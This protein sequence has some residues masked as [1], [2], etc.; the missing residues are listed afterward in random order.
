MKSVKAGT[1]CIFLLI[2]AG[3]LSHAATETEELDSLEV[4]GYLLGL[5]EPAPPEIMGDVVV[6]T[7]SSSLR[8]VGI[9]FADEG[10][11]SVHWF[12]PLMVSEDPLERLRRGKNASPYREAGISFHVREIPR[13]LDRLEYRLVING[14]W[15][16]DPTNPN[17]RRDGISGS[18][19]SVLPLPPSQPYGPVSVMQGGG[20]NLVF[21]GPPGESV[22]VAGSFNNWDPFMYE[23]REGPAGVYTIRI[24]L[25][26]G[27]YQ[28]VFFHRGERVVDQFNHSRVFSR[29][30][31]AASEIVVQNDR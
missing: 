20:L 21:Q 3:G 14:L 29:E 26:A 6:F 16:V 13:G 17:T 27:R 7:A 12:R 2:F 23:L 24:P 11:A 30:G 5:S 19:L 28:Y 15:T 22:T 9:A 25:P 10:F 1:I 4:L 18:T 31:E 8:R